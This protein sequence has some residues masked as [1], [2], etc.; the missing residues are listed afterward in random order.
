MP[1]QPKTVGAV[2]RSSYYL[3][4]RALAQSKRVEHSIKP[5]T[6]NLNVMAKVY[7]AEGIPIDRKK[8]KGNRIKAAYYCEDG[9]C[10][11][12]VNSSLPREPKLFAMAHELKHHYLDQEQILNGQIECGDYNANELIEKGGEVFAAEFIYPE[13]EM[14]ELL[15]QMKI[16][17]DN[18]TAETVV[19]LKRACPACVSYT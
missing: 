13:Q 17:S 15:G 9:E 6:L 19:L 18:C 11:V 8:L 12:L 10:S 2:S 7:K 5:E 16:S 14:R 4:C 1:Q 3:Q